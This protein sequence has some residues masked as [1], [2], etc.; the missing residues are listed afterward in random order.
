MRGVSVD[1][2]S[3]LPGNTML[4]RTLSSIVTI[5]A[6]AATSSAQVRTVDVVASDFKF[7]APDSIAA[8]IT[9]FRLV[10]KGPELHHMQ[11][12]RLEQG[13]TF[14][15]FETAIRNPGPPPAWVSFVGGPNA[16]IPNG[17]HAT[18]VT[19]ALSAGNYVILCVIPSPDGTP[20]IAKGMYKSLTVTGLAATTVQAGARKADVVMT[21]TD[22]NF[23][24][25]KPL[26]AGRRRIL[27][28]NPSPQWHEA[29]LAKLPPGVPA[30]DFLDWMAA[31]M[32]GRPPIVPMGG[33]VALTPG[34]ENM[35]V[36][37]LE[38][39]RYALYCFL[40]DAKDGKE[41]VEHGMFK[42]I[43]VTK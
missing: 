40:P 35:L 43:T 20:H 18:T 3:L 29:F 16:G 1:S 8:G 26:T 5:A 28:R 17:Q 36:V 15:D 24:L 27:I 34:Q 7:T 31:G 6:F 33:I 42:E 12:A 23:H 32:K 21:L 38:A 14:A 9:T 41:H 13:K 39:G 11:V 22:Y 30:K 25:D 37:D 2:A 10:N 19:T 4:H